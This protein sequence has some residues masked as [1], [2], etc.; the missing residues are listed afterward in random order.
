MRSLILIEFRYVVL[1]TFP[2]GP[3][4]AEQKQSKRSYMLNYTENCI[5]ISKYDSRHNSSNNNGSMV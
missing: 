2:S 4:Y 5:Q 3:I 1:Y